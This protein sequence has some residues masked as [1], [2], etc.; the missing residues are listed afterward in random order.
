MP[1]TIFGSFV[2]KIIRYKN[3]GYT[4]VF[5]SSTGF[6]A[7]IPDKGVKDPFWSPHGPELM[8]ISITSW[9][10]KGCS[11][12]YKHSTTHGQHMLFDDYK[13]VVDQAADMGT[14]QVALGG[15]NPN[16]HPDFCEILKYTASKKVVPNYT[17]NG[18]GLTDEIFDATRK[19]CGAVAVSAYPPFDEATKTIKRLIHNGI[20]TNVHFILDAISIDTAINW[21]NEPPKFLRGI[22]AIVFLNYKPLGRKVY[23]KKLLRNSTRLQEFFRLATSLQKSLKVGF[24]AC[25]VSGVFAHTNTNIAMVDACDAGRFS[26]Y[27]SEDLKVYPCSFQSGLAGGDQL[28]SATTLLDIW[29]KSRNMKAFRSYFSSNRCGTCSHRSVCMNGCPLFDELVVCG[30]R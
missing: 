20:K 30:N 7:R 25:C 2:L 8:D 17:T 4:S 1:I 3:L 26:M 27:V 12:C 13:N 28:D 6:F 10:D 11:F 24:D 29:L 15:G 5:N 14:F 22:N 19:Y 18:R 9:C 21:L 23:E 16:Q